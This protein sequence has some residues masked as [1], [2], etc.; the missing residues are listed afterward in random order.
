MGKNVLTLFVFV[1][2]FGLL[3]GC[4]GEQE[5]QARKE[6][7]GF[8]ED[9][10]LGYGEKEKAPD[11]G[12]E[13]VLEAEIQEDTNIPED[14]PF[15]KFYYS[16]FYTCDSVSDC[17]E[18]E[19]EIEK[20]G[21]E[22]VVSCKEFEYRGMDA[23]D[24]LPGHP[25]SCEDSQDCVEKYFNKID[26]N[27]EETK[28]SERL[29]KV[30]RCNNG[31]C[32]V[33]GGTFFF[34]LSMQPGISGSF[35]KEESKGYWQSAAIPFSITEF[36]VSGETAKISLKNTVNDEI[37]LTEITLGGLG[38]ISNPLIFS[39]LEEKIVTV[40]GIEECIE[41]ETFMLDVSITYNNK[42]TGMTGKKQTGVKPL[43]GT[44][45]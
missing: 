8:G 16:Y 39:A 26:L 23:F 41:G 45:S 38:K 7:T 43:V 34:I 35:K 36:N 27:E 24:W 3:A 9:L 42:D 2:L 20:T 25:F 44:C 11:T 31:K 33:L 30:T 17:G 37:E 15:D 18:F 10:P 40:N 13:C 4:V 32:E 5:K 12:K 6:G 29:K 28:I 1:L 21:L 22:G 19:K 14:Y